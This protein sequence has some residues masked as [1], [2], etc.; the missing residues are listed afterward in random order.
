MSETFSALQ[1]SETIRSAYLE[2]LLSAFDFSDSTISSEFRQSLEERFE[3]S[4]GPFVQVTP[5]YKRSKSLRELA[6]DG[7]ISPDFS[8]NS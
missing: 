1:A 8:S 3:L 4:K 2:Y 6:D 5:P 7:V